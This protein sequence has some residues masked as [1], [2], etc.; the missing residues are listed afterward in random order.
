MGG[1]WRD[2]S[3]W[4][5]RIFGKIHVVHDI[6]LNVYHYKL[7]T[8]FIYNR[9]FYNCFTLCPFFCFWCVYHIFSIFTKLKRGMQLSMCACIHVHVHGSLGFAC[10]RL[11]VWLPVTKICH[12]LFFSPPVLKDQMSLSSTPEPFDKLQPNL[13]QSILGWRGFNF[14]QI[15][16]HALFQGEIIMK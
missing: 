1:S 2:K 12:P 8:N 16:G 10:G 3:G 6:Y 14:V 9:K 13:A 5:V 4:V 7:L 11:D 15:K